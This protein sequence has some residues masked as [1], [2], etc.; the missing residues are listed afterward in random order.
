MSDP[1]FAD[2]VVGNVAIAYGFIADKHGPAFADAVCDAL[3]RQ[4]IDGQAYARDAAQLT[5]AT[6]SMKMINDAMRGSALDDETW[7][8][9]RA[10]TKRR[11]R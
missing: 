8:A 3:S 6:L 5:P 10:A 11:R 2:Q 4:G 9:A 1:S 7:F